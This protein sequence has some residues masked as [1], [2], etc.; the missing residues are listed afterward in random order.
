MIALKDKYT[1]IFE[2]E[3]IFDHGRSLN[4]DER[5]LCNTNNELF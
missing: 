5:Q 4:S 2:T 1:S 3:R